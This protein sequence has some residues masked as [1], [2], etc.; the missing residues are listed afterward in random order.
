[1]WLILGISSWGEISVVNRIQF[2]LRFKQCTCIWEF[3]SR[4]LFHSPFFLLTLFSYLFSVGK[5]M[6]GHYRVIFLEFSRQVVFIISSVLFL[7]CWNLG[8]FSAFSNIAFYLKKKVILQPDTSQILRTCTQIIDYE[9]KIYLIYFISIIFIVKPLENVF[10]TNHWILF[11]ILYCFT[12]EGN[13][14]WTHIY[15]ICY[16]LC[17]QH[18]HSSQFLIIAFLVQIHFCLRDLCCWTTQGLTRRHLLCLYVFLSVAFLLMHGEKKI[19]EGLY[20]MS[21]TVLI[22]SSLFFTVSVDA[23][24]LKLS[25]NLW[26]FVN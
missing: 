19:L 14:W 13:I 21:T 15:L 2:S 8:C 25:C 3:T 26:R 16:R 7:S 11:S 17:Q 23:T 4:P 22:W 24:Y 6:G 20:F 18:N 1:M 5:E 9:N 10:S 12:K